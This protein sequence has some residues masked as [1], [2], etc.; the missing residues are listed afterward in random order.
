MSARLL[1]PWGRPAALA[2]LLALTAGFGRLG[3]SGVQFIDSWT[4][5]RVSAEM[6]QS[7]DW[8]IPTW[9]GE[10]FLEKPPLLF[11]LS[12]ALFRAFGVSEFA[13]QSLSG[14]AVAA[15][16]LLVFA[17]G[18]RAAGGACGLVAALL[19]GATPMF[20]KWGRTYLT[21]PLFTLLNLAAL[22][23]GWRAAGAPAWWPA[24]GA[25]AA[26]A[27]LTRGAAAV[28]LLLTL[29]YLAW[30]SRSSGEEGRSRTLL[31]AAAVVV[32][33]AVSLPWHWVAARRAGPQLART[34]V[35]VQTLE[36]AARNLV[37][38]PRARTPL[39]YPWH[40][41]RTGWPVLPLLCWG[42]VRLR[43]AWRSAAV[44]AGRLDRALLVHAALQVAMLA[45]VASRSGRYVLP[46][47]PVLSLLAA[48][49]LAA[50]LGEEGGRR[51][52]R[53][54][55]YA[56]IGSAVAL[57]VWPA[58]I[59]TPRG[60][61]FRA[62]A[63][64]VEREVPGP[65]RLEVEPALVDPWFE[66]AYWFYLGRSPHPGAG[67][68]PEADGGREGSGG[69]IAVQRVVAEPQAALCAPPRC[70]VLERA[71]PYA[72]VQLKPR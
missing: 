67:G 19:L 38:S 46:L 72:L 40:L 20:V 49:G 6:A 27:V 59:G 71:A 64:A 31:A 23:C 39:Y 48:R 16:V 66:R 51:L 44:P 28:P 9:A 4:Y 18:A 58:P 35:G 57:A 12:A 17:A 1:G 53:V 60:K 37:D 54:A 15:S 62:L 45:G 50:G 70:L 34:Y 41:A 65:V 22:L 56:A 14:A 30:T 36:R 33:V 61:P 26:L 55:A 52:R 13:A 11:W 8:A 2:V 42:L 24:T 69:A 10:P 63:R 7:G 47:Y 32:F 3:E 5:A 29:A 21:D 25:L 43:R 68:G